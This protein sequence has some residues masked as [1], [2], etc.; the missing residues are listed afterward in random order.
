[1]GTAAGRADAD[2][3]LRDEVKTGC[4]R[5]EG[6]DGMGGNRGAAARNE[7]A[8]V[9]FLARFVFAFFFCTSFDAANPQV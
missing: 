9:C 1:V 8:I 3:A 2:E 4:S 6:W 5:G 7:S